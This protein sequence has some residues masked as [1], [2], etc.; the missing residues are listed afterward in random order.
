[1]MHD[2]LGFS[3]LHAAL[4]QEFFG[5]KTQRHRA[6]VTSTAPTINVS[7]SSHVYDGMTHAATAT[8]VGADGMPVPTE[9]MRGKR[10]DEINVLRMV[11]TQIRMGD[12]RR[13]E[14]G[15]GEDLSFMAAELG[16]ILGSLVKD[17]SS[18]FAVWKSGG[19]LL[20]SPAI[21]YLFPEIP[22]WIDQIFPTYYLV[23]PVVRI[24]QQGGGWSDVA[25]HVFVLV[26]LDVILVGVVAL[27]LRRMR[28]AVA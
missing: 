25:A 19:I 13:R 17:M 6:A 15:R 8:A 18:L 20:F 1:M 26:G 4:A 23:E 7:A 21:I 5:R 3:I 2:F 28:G 9:A 12:L 11:K 14:S 27:A 16:L 10:Q 24:S 22:Q